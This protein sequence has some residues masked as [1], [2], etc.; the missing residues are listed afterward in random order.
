[1]ND[2]SQVEQPTYA[3]A[4]PNRELLSTLVLGGATGLIIW[5]LGLILNRYVFDVFFCQSGLSNLCAHELDYAAGVSVAVGSI[6]ALVGLIWLRVYRPLLVVLAAAISLWGVAQL[7][8]GASWYWGFLSAVVLYLI[9]YG[10]FAWTA[11][12]R[13]FWI[14]LVATIALVVAV[15][16][17]LVL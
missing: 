5:G 11:R 2:E 16:V 4:M 1:M 15:R 10:L 6:L 12:V 8:I 13:V 14:A 17:A 7:A 9:A 3:V